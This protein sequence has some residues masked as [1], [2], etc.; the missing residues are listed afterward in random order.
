MMDKAIGADYKGGMSKQICPW[1]GQPTNNDDTLKGYKL[2][3]CGKPACVR[4]QMSETWKIRKRKKAAAAR[5][6]NHV[7]KIT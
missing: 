4:R 5:R 1:C 6:R 7:S 3:T 2:K